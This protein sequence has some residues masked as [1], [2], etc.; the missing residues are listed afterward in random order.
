MRSREGDKKGEEE[1][2]RE[3]GGGKRGEEERD[4]GGREGWYREGRGE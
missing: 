3:R 4:R 2:G 1:R